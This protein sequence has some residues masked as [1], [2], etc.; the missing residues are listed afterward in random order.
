MANTQL[1]GREGRLSPQ[2]MARLAQ[3]LLLR[4]PS[5]VKQGWVLEGWPRSL[6]A[7]V[8]FTSVGAAGAG[9]SISS[10]GGTGSEMGGKEKG[11]R[12]DSTAGPSVKVGVDAGGLQHPVVEC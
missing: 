3:H 9:G 2:L 5:A 10:S 12:R 8:L 1:T 7:A 4:Q 11:A 6:S